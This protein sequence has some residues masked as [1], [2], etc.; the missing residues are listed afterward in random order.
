VKAPGNRGLLLC[1]GAT[2]PRD[3]GKGG[4]TVVARFL[5]ALETRPVAAG[6]SGTFP[7]VDYLSLTDLFLVGLALG[8][9]PGGVSLCD[10]RTGI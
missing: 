9:R 4:G 8:P 3:G 1:E 6:P 10:A 7:S 5:S 2:P